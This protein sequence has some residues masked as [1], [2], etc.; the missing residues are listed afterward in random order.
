MKDF[1]AGSILSDIAPMIEHIPAAAL[2]LS[3]IAD[4][5]KTLFVNH[6]ISMFGYAVEEFMNG[7]ISWLDIVHPDD[8]VMVSKTV[9]DYESH[10]VNSF[11]LYYRLVTKNGDVV[12]VTEYN[13]VN[14]AENGEVLCYDTFIVSTAQDEGSRRIIDD[15]YRQQVVLNDILISLHDSDLDNALQIILDRTGQYLDTSRALLFKDSPDHKTCKIVYE[16]CN[17]D[18]SSV[19][20]LDYSITYETGMPEIYVALQTTGNLLINHGEIPENCKEEF[21]AEGLVASA[22]F[23]VYLDGDHYGFVCFD[24]CVVER[25]WDDNTVRF[26]KNIANLISTVIA[27]QAAAEKLAQNQRSYEAVLNNIDTYIFV[28]NPVNYEIIFANRAFKETFGEDCVGRPYTDYLTLPEATPGLAAHDYPEVYCERSREWLGVSIEDITWV[29]GSPACLATCYNITAKKLFADTLEERIRER[30]AELRRMTE[31]AERAKEKAEDATMAKSQFLANMSHEIRTPMN[32]ILGLS[33]LLSEH[34]LPPVQ[35]EHVRN[36]RRASNILLNIINDILDISKLEAGRL[37]LVN[38]H[39]SLTQTLDHV[40]SLLR[41]MAEGKGLEYNL[42][43]EPGLPRCLYGDDIRLRQVLINILGNAVKFTDKGSVEL[44]AHQGDD[45]MLYFRISDTGS[46]IRPEEIGSIFEPFAQ[47]DIHKNRK[48]QGTGLGLP[49]CR[50][51]V[52]LM[53]G[54]IEVESTYGK[55][56][57]FTVAIPLVPGDEELL[58]REHAAEIRVY[59]PSARVLVVDDIE[60]NLY[61]A[62][63]LL[64]EYGIKSVLASSGADGMEMARN[65][66]FDIIFMDHMM[67]GINGLEATRAIRSLGGKNAET[68]IIALTAN[69]VTEARHLFEEAGMNDFLPK[70]LE[71]RKLNA[72]LEKWLPKEKLLA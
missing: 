17:R 8:R 71:A 43:I 72:I 54:R 18:I 28:K 41:G 51:L 7:E 70:P 34:S 35:H 37:T 49:I 57:V 32:A 44:D 68:P 33:E 9:A 38:V 29:D 69:V 21:E 36:I 24:D 12:P 6:N 67:P 22:I 61:V 45:G 47:S 53:G 25:V 11:K 3:H 39:Y 30:T 59:A 48:I 27:R 15:Y 5:W 46:G 40:S 60:V 52:E 56:S 2:R 16:W 65:D 31:E 23:A 13:T 42:N 64:E 10:G 1:P 50:S 63:A 14:R 4:K 26:L 58:E 66:D 20:D 62:E 55:G 19:K